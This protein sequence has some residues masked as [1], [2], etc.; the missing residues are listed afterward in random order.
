MIRR[1]PRSTLFPYTTL[2]R[3]RRAEDRTHVGD[4]A[5][6]PQPFIGEPVVVARLLLGRQPD[7]AQL[8]GRTLGRHG[9]PV[10]L[11][12]DLAVGRAPAVRDPRAR[13]RPHD[14]LHGGDQ[15]ARGPPQRDRVAPPHVDVRLPVG[16]DH[17]LVTGQIGPEDGTQRL[18]R[19]RELVVVTRPLLRFEVAEQ[20]AQVADDGPQLGDGG[21]V[22]RTP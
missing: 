13:A 5:H 21:P 2:F 10:V 22:R 8:I 3:S 14:R 1:P 17:Y 7:P 19:P 15:A 9:D 20:G 18:R 16:D 12:H 6:G 11:V 4:V